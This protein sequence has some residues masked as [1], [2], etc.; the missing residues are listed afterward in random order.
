[1]DVY[2][3]EYIRACEAFGWEGGPEFNTAIQPMVNKREKRAAMWSQSRFFASLPFRNIQ[4]ESYDNIL[5]MFE[6]RMGRWGAFLYRNRL[7][8]TATDEVFAVAEAGQTSFQLGI[9]V[10][11]SGRQR[12]RDIHA[13]YIPEIASDGEAVESEITIAIDG[14]PTTALL[15]DH[16]R[17]TVEFDSPPGEGAVLTWSGAYS[18]WVRFDQD[19]LPMSIDNKS[20]DGF[21]MNGAVDLIGVPPP[22]LAESSGSS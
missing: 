19:R 3:R 11:Q 2:I 14:T 5:E 9:Y 1:M 22:R 12:K 7:A 10:G 21:F 18:Y 15:I 13:L 20:E 6:D 17:G 16:D 4:P 8:H